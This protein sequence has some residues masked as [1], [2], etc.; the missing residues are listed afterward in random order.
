MQ[1]K[2][3]HIIINLANQPNNSILVDLAN[4]FR[5]SH[6]EYDYT[7]LEEKTMDIASKLDGKVDLVAVYGGDGTVARVAQEM[8]GKDIPMAVLPGGTANVIAKEF[9]IPMELREAIELIT[10]NNGS[11]IKLIDTGVCNGKPF[12]IRVSFGIMA[13][14]VSH[15]NRKMKDSFGQLAYGITAIN[16]LL[17]LPLRTYYLKVDGKKIK[18]KGVSLCITNIGNIGITDFNILPDIKTDDGFFDLVLLSQA[19]IISL[20]RMAGSI[21]FQL[22]SS[23][24]KRWKCKEISIDLKRKQSLIIDDEEVRARHIQISLV[25]KSLKILVP[26]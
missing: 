10:H 8:I 16:D 18:Q 20:L 9:G 1:F 5:D 6:I 21:L 22:D 2:R 3:V 24:L 25:P 12:I 17:E 14:M 11:K 19:D 13:D 4:G 23:V 26:V 15:T 7:L